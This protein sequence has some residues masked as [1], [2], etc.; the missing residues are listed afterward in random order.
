MAE[1][2][3]TVYG[4]KYV[5]PDEESARGFD[6]ALEASRI[7]RAQKEESFFD[8]SAF[9]KSIIPG[10]I[11]GTGSAIQG[12]GSLIQSEG[13]KETGREVRDSG[14]T[15][16]EKYMDLEPYRRYTTGAQLGQTAGAMAPAALAALLATLA[17]PASVPAAG[18]AA[19]TAGV[20]GLMGLAQ[21][22]G[23]ISEDIDQARKRGVEVTP[24]QEQKQA[25][26]QGTIT[27]ILEA[28]PFHKAGKLIGLGRL[29]SKAISSGA[30]EEVEEVAKLITMANKPILGAGY[31]ARALKQAA[32]ESVTEA[33]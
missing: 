29:G 19:I 25:F 3:R 26:A 5:F 2:Y 24:E 18:V 9:L 11:R 16:S 28:I 1:V 23:E 31:G 12:I 20:S 27:G 10:A 8:A 4:N 33:L 14:D 21:G 6:A 13:T 7:A 32:V 17:A 30:G 15:F 22:A